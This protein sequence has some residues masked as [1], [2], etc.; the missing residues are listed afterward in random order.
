RKPEHTTQARA[1]GFNKPV[2]E[3]FCYKLEFLLKKHK[4]KP[5]QIW[6]GDETITPTVVQPPKVIA[7]NGTKQVQQTVSAERGTNV[8][9]LAFISA[10][11]TTVPP[12]FVFPR[13]KVLPPMYESGPLGCIGLAHNSGWMSK[14]FQSSSSFPWLRKIIHN[15][16]SVAFVRQP[17]K[18]LR[19]P[20]SV[21]CKR[22]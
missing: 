14:F 2:V 9:M 21:F 7:C 17:F 13:K 6:N 11:G 1:A 20:G 12:V 19:L 22:K 15:K 16:P 4:F 8:T 18:S 10:S 3:N 5:H